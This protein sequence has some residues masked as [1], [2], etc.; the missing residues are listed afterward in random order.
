[1]MQCAEI[2]PVLEIVD[3]IMLAEYWTELP[4]KAL[5]EQKLHSALI[6]IQSVVLV[7]PKYSAVYDD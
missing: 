3:N 5:P 1:M 4:P 2:F 7:L 6:D